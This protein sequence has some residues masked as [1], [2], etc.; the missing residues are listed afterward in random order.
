MYVYYTYITHTIAL[1][2]WATY[3]IVMSS[4]VFEIRI[5]AYGMVDKKV[6]K[7]GNSAHVYLPAEWVGKKVK[8]LL[9]EPIEDE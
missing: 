8:V 5:N 9:L 2:V 6:T 7:H 4:E 3:V 1:F